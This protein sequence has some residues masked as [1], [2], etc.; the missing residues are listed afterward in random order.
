MNIFFW[1][2]GDLLLWEI[3]PLGPA[4]IKQM[5]DWLEMIWLVCLVLGESLARVYPKDKWIMPE[6]KSKLPMKTLRLLLLSGS[7]KSF[8]V[9]NVPFFFLFF[10]SRS[11]FIL[12]WAMLK[13]ENS[14]QIEGKKSGDRMCFYYQKFLTRFIACAADLLKYLLQWILLHEE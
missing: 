7:K 8:A 4:G 1:T 13:S 2:L 3:L 12:V 14:F 9:G 5:P 10:F 11:V 6:E